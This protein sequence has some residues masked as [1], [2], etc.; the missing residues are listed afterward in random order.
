MNTIVFPIAPRAQG[1]QVADLHAALQL[2]LDRDIIPA[3]ELSLP[4]APPVTLAPERGAQMYGP[5]T[6][7]VVSLFQKQ[8]S[9]Q[10][11]GTV[12]EPTATAI[13]AI[14]RDWGLLAEPGVA[15]PF[16]VG[17][18]VRRE[19]GVFLKDGRVQAFH[20]GEGGDIRLGDDTTDAEGRYTIRYQ[21]LP[22][23]AGLNL[24]IA[25]A[26][27]DG[28]P[29]VS[30]DVIT[31]AK[32]LEIVNLTVPVTD[33]RALERRLE[34]RIVL[35]H[36]LPAE[37]TKLRL[38]GRAFGG[39]ET[40]LAETATQ[41]YGLYAMPYDPAG[42][43]LGLEIRAVDPAGKEVP[44]SRTMH[45]VN[46]QPRT[47]V[48]LVAPRKVQ[49]LGS[50]YQRITAD[51]APQVGTI[52]QLTKARENAE[53]QDLTVLNR[54]TGWDARLI[55]LVATAGKLSA[56]P[57]VKLPQE[58]LYGLFRAGLPSDK[59]KLAQISPAAVEK[60]LK[61]VST[62][63]IVNLSDQQIGE[64][65]KQF[66]TFAV[67]TRLAVPAPGSRSTYVDLL[68]S[69]G[70]SAEVQTKFGSVYAN[71]RGEP[72]KLWEKAAAAGIPPKDIQTLQRQGKL[73]FLT[74][75]SA[76]V[77]GRLQQQGVNDP[78]QLVDK[79]FHQ[80]D[81]WK[82]E[83]KAVAGTSNEKLAALIPP[84]YAGVTVEDRLDAYAKDMARKVRLSYPTEVVANI[85]GQD[86][87][88]E[89]KLGDAR[90]AVAT[91]LKNAAPQGFKLG[92][93]PVE[94]F[95][96]SHPQLLA[97]SGAGG[98]GVKE[99]LKTLQRVHQMTPSDEAMRVLLKL[100][101]TS[102][103][104]VTAMSKPEFL[105]RHGK[106]FPS[107]SVAELVY[108]K[109][110]QVDSVTYNWL[111]IARKL[112]SEAPVYGISAPAAVRNTVKNELIKQ[113]P[114]MESLF[115]SMDFCE[116]EHCRSV[117][118]PAAYL[119]DLF[120]F[121][122]PDEAVWKNFLQNW[123]ESHGNKDYEKNYGFKKPY[124]ALIARR[125]DLPNIPLTCENTTTALPYI[126]VVN[127]ILE[128]YVANGK[129]AAEAARD[130]GGATTAELLAEPQNVVRGAYDS[131]LAARYPLT[132]PFDLW[133][134]TVR[135]FSGYFET[136]LPQV[137][138]TFRKGDAL[139]APAATQPYDRAAIFIESLGLAPS[140]Q[141]IFVEADP[142][143]KWYDLYGYPTARPAI[144]APTNATNA[145][146]TI[147]NGDVAGFKAGDPITYFDV[148]ANA[149]QPET[150]VVSSIGA[151]DT[152]T[153][154]TLL[155][156]TGVWA[157][158]PVAGDLL[159]YD[160]PAT[161]ASAKTLSRRLGVTYKELV[162]IIRTEF[163]NPGLGDLDK[164][165][166]SLQGLLLYR[167]RKSFY[168][169]NKDLLGK[170][171]S[172]LSAADQQ[173]FDALLS[174]D[175]RVLNEV[176]AVERRLA[177]LTKEYAGSGF[178]AQA[179]L[180]KKLQNNEFDNFLV[181]VD[182]DAGCNFDLTTLRYSFRQDQ[183]RRAADDVAFLKINL[184]VRLWRKLGWTMEDTDRALQALVPRNAPFEKA[185]L[186]K[187]PLKSGLLYLAHLK[188][189]DEQLPVGKQSRLKLLALWSDIPTSGRKSL[190]GQLFLARSV[191]KS[192]PIFDDPLGKYLQFFDPAD[193]KY[194]PF[195]WDSTQPEN[196]KTGNVP[197]KSHLLAV[198]GALGL[199][200]ADIVSVLT[201]AGTTL[202]KA[203]LSLARVSQLYRHG[204][205]AK[206]LK[207]SVNELISLKQLAGIDPFKPLHPEPLATMA[208][209]YPFTQ[210]LRFVEIARQVK[211]SGLKI[212]DLD[213]LLRHRFD[214]TGK[215]RS[216][217][218]AALALIK[219][220]S[221]GVRSIQ[222]EQTLPADAGSIS[223][224]VLRQKLALVLPSEVVERF[225]AMMDGTVEYTASKPGVPPADQLK[226]AGFASEPAIRQVS[227]NAARQEQK[228]TFRG[229]LF[230]QQK[231]D[232]KGKLP[233]P[234][235]PA[236]F[237]ASPTFGRL[238][239]D[240]QGQARAFFTKHLQKQEANMAPAAGFLDPG[241]FDLLFA[242]PAAGLNDT[243]QQ[244]LIRQ[245]RGRLA[246][247][248]LP[249]LQQRLIRQFVVQTLMAQTGA[250]PVLVESLLTDGRLLGDPQPLL[251]A[252]ASVGARAVTA[253]FFASADGSGAAL[254][255]ASF[256]NGDTGLKDANGTLLRPAAAKSA[257]FE[258]YLEV[259][260]PGAYRFFVTLDKQ[261]AEATLRFDHLPK[262]VLQAVAATA[263]AEI[264]EFVE[265]KPGVLYR[266]TWELRKLNG[267]DA[268]LRVQ[269]ETLPKDRLAQ[270]TL[271][272]A[273]V[274]DR[275]ERA[276]ILLSKALQL[277]QALTLSEREVRYLLTHSADF[278]G[279][280]L[281]KLPTRSGQD[282]PAG[283]KALFAQFL[284][285]AGYARLKRD[286]AGGTDDLIE[287]FEAATPAQAYALLATLTRRE[288]GTV[289]ATA[290][291]LFA[292][293]AFSSEE[294][295]LRLWD[296]LQVVERFGV[297][298]ATIVG[299]TGIVRAGATPEQRFG[300]AIDVKQ[301]IKARFEADSWQRVAQP[302]FDGLRRR[303]RDALVALIM[304]KQNF[305]RIE[306][307]F[308][309]FLIDPGME[310][311]V[312]T[313]R[314]RLAIASAQLFTQCCLL[315]LEKQVHPSAIL[316]ADQWEWMKRYRVWEANRKIFLFPENWLEPEF[317]DDK[318][319]LFAELEGN[320]LQ[321]DVSS[322]L[323]EDA[324]LV[325]LRKLDELARLDIVAMHMEKRDDPAM[326]KLH[327]IGRTHNQPYKYFYRRNAHQ[328]WTP[329]EPVSAEIE[330]NHLAPVIWRD[331]LYLFW[332]TFLDKP[333]G[334]AQATK[335]LS[336][337]ST[338][339]LR[340][341]QLT[342]SQAMT[343]LKGAAA[344]KNI[345]AQLHWSEYFQGE[346]ST[347]ASGVGVTLTASSQ[348]LDFDN[349]NVFIHVSKEASDERGYER[350]VYIHLDSP[351][352][353]AFY[354][355]GRNSLPEEKPYGSRPT[356]PYLNLSAHANGYSGSNAFAARFVQRIITGDREE[357]H[358]DTATILQLGGQYTVLPCDNATEELPPVSDFF[359]VAGVASANTLTSITTDLPI[360]VRGTAVPPNFYASQVAVFQGGP[361]N[362]QR[363][364]V[365][366]SATSGGKTVLALDTTKALT[367]VPAAGQAARLGPKMAGDIG[368]LVQ[369]VFYQDNAHALYIEPNLTERTIEEWQDWVTRTWVP[370]EES[371]PWLDDSDWW[372][373]HVKPMTPETKIPIPIDPGDPV[374]RGAIDVESILPVVQTDDWLV[375]DVTELLYDGE[376]I[377]PKG[378]GGFEVVRATE[379]AGAIAGGSTL[380]NL[381]SGSGIPQGSAVV[382]PVGT[383]PDVPGRSRVSGELHVIGSEGLNPALA[384]N[385][386]TITGAGG[387]AGR[388][389]GA[390]RIIR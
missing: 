40:L 244:E 233:T 321:G 167:D 286:I 136:P 125:P 163:V 274:V 276:Y 223:E 82:A 195:R 200:A 140:E 202:E 139:F 183:A 280:N 17:G 74:A 216:N 131:V 1:T 257:R 385:F 30:S 55:A 3:A 104:D 384:H 375:N 345:E 121:L 124:E 128:Y 64:V 75:N 31:Q 138:E 331:R 6:Q 52:Q 296:A 165:G 209:D 279:I 261:A 303:Q 270:L 269:G 181:L 81:K 180:S 370:E 332:V 207:L 173:R 224:D 329:W 348:L 45:D 62:V 366:G 341:T 227:Y 278:G 228:L 145:T 239:D 84:V 264:S 220:I 91:F 24:R 288:E 10:T 294:P 51:V 358:S 19:S 226:P 203:E 41:Q 378:R 283:A 242:P 247:A 129:L 271:Y 110:Q 109:A 234:V 112:D 96:K 363:A 8:R 79:G 302:I 255:T 162:E 237:V 382:A 339:E 148:S 193:S 272:P 196:A 151:P 240:V 66:E 248:F 83:L 170:S 210:T 241:D 130:T 252:F 232:L 175:W 316:N 134:E 53:R 186:A 94:L 86:T 25:V 364:L 113:F 20:V 103:R 9:L 299:W 262:P 310:P 388:L 380:V 265:L 324:F 117:L 350:G 144:A 190:Y 327:V 365:V 101:L 308:E 249:Y 311:V 106:K 284:R 268:R 176:D 325:Y 259:P 174:A 50:E 48:N 49:P 153:G 135:G 172:A 132:L 295:L 357:T 13:N 383:T 282:T 4:G 312:Q 65:K 225:L 377:G 187:Q 107:V 115:G 245:R 149:L 22:G 156:L 318:S 97:G 56:D 236:P 60:A 305:A 217:R 246:K 63:G 379:L 250:D 92:Q 133:L 34:G 335:V 351:F 168:D 198:Q 336:S 273:S 346:W 317:R 77:V 68:K 191:L 260:A 150:K 189:L 123:S 368:P 344:T 164:L 127:E 309:Y 376:L 71:D 342:M 116:C 275:A 338:E 111:T 118:S 70:V 373:K 43:A 194:K 256:P 372:E 386:E 361:L 89:L 301:A 178:D 16:V 46:E 47:I 281:S 212:E 73:T 347:R 33:E 352:G 36:G 161:L 182:P 169:Q 27:I 199:T 154:R 2:L 205:L 267:G 142:L 277:I 290:E 334:T 293:P 362:G 58:A 98:R 258:G 26:D 14:L 23:V 355:A 390:G 251:E 108:R 389:G 99:A 76:E 300:I 333:D 37:G 291:A 11:N 197:L 253:A 28:N 354:L 188:D 235:A 287:V 39:G 72:G 177:D 5:I 313:S 18:Q 12:D 137:L 100:G 15:R 330:G 230:D 185:N 374:F 297:P 219:S 215:Y 146:L 59:L 44:L 61:R 381:H 105:R 371:L 343:S 263:G 126:D 57:A 292:T 171:R 289:R 201:D 266:F 304:F 204:L 85:V 218:D 157:T 35:E 166:V 152:A 88:G 155:T 328:M 69:S 208:E 213:Y 32:P 93:T 353:K 238:V 87:A 67:T 221:E 95:T 38:Y 29:L 179:W 367:A 158:P 80:A 42:K 114:T 229:V 54:Q 141:A 307:L 192:D 319:H 7:R 306:Q 323:V 320:L 206:A 322:D 243:Q 231:N 184:F 349:N 211:D 78:T 102:A 143:S 298:V 360:R 214:E 90:P 147:P 122:D 120:Q 356:I 254:A 21:M 359:V 387:L 285:L 340:V 326:N 315:N 159:V 369:P 337:S 314:V 119:V 222:A 160:A